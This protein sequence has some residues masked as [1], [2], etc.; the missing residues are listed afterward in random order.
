MQLKEIKMKEMAFLLKE[1]GIIR[2]I[3]LRERGGVAIIIL[4]ILISFNNL[5]WAFLSTAQLE[6]LF[7]L[8]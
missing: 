2:I 6:L 4:I 3:G 7:L 1:I 8:F 5:L